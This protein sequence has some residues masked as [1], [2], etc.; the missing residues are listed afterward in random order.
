MVDAA[1]ADDDELDDAD[2]FSFECSS[3]VARVWYFLLERA[4]ALSG[5]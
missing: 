1:E 2:A 5:W 4:L 3:T